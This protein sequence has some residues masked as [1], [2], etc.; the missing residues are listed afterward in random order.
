MSAKEAALLSILRLAQCIC[1]KRICYL[2]RENLPLERDIGSPAL[3]EKN[4]FGEILVRLFNNCFYRFCLAIN[5]SYSNKAS[6]VVVP[7]VMSVA[8]SW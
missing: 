1:K 6:C 5:K 8:S 4:H 2:K 7:G 3:L